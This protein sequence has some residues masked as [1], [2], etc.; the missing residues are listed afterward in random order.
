SGVLR[1]YVELSS[2]LV[3]NKNLYLP[4]DMAYGEQPGY[5]FN[6]NVSFERKLGNSLS[7]LL[8]YD[9]KAGEREKT[10]HSFRMDGQFYF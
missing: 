2:V 4:S 5:N 6:W 7:V 10:F 3:K 9:G 8:I 1:G